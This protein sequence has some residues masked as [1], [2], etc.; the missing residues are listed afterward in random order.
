[1]FVYCND[2][3]FDETTRG[4]LVRLQIHINDR[5]FLNF[6]DVY[7]YRKHV[8]RCLHTTTCATPSCTQF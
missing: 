7:L 8:C 6:T 4:M 3:L 1:M 2:D 5:K